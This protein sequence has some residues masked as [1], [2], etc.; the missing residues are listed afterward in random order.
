MVLYNRT[1]KELS[2]KIEDKMLRSIHRKKGN[3][4]LRSDVSN[5]GSDS[6]VSEALRSL[7]DKKELVRIAVGVYA[8]TYRDPESGA[9]R[10]CADLRSLT[11]EALA[12]LW[13]SASLQQWRE[14]HDSDQNC[15]VAY[16]SSPEHRIKRKFHLDDQLIWIISVPSSTSS[17]GECFHSKSANKDFFANH[18]DGNTVKKY[19]LQLAQ[20]HHV[21]YKNIFQDRWANSITRLAGDEVAPDPVKD[22]LVALKRAGKVSTDEMAKLLI[23]YL[24]EKKNVRPV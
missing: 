6:Q 20:K 5:L 21:T 1:Q 8:K 24:R 18:C 10:A 13:K 19:I 12:K 16:I 14:V 11:N 7:Q 22:A 15:W 9:A 2:V 23:T 3:V 17:H 4:I